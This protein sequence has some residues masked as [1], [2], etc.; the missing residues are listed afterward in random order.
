[1][2]SNK[3]PKEDNVEI[4]K[5]IP[6]SKEDSFYIEWGKES[7]KENIAVFND[8]FKLLITLDTVLLSAYLGFYDKVLGNLPFISWQAILPAICV[9]ISLIASVIGIYPFSK[10]VHLSVPQEIRRYKERRSK[11]KSVFLTIATFT[12]VVG[13]IA[14]LIARVIPVN[15][16]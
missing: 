7:L 1:M 12:L 9:I 2:N 15:S 6:P 10:S 11:F 14:L 13:F 4:T 5:G 3:L 16:P 8:T